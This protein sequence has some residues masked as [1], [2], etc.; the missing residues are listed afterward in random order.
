MEIVLTY[1][2]IDKPLLSLKFW[3]FL[4][5]IFSFILLNICLFCLTVHYHHLLNK[6]YHKIKLNSLLIGD[7]SL[8]SSKKRQKEVQSPKYCTDSKNPTMPCSKITRVPNFM[9]IGKT[10]KS[11]TTF[12][13]ILSKTD[14]QRRKVWMHERSSAIADGPRDALWQ[15]KSC[16]LLH[17]RM[18]NPIWKGLQ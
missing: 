14:R 16:Q 3:Y 9:K 11:L 5:V 1:C 12:W 17:N 4:L 15:L 8:T 6:H 2:A 18:K 13:E 7:I 10:V